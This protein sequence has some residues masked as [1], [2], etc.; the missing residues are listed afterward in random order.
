MSFTALPMG[1]SARVQRL[2]PSAL[3]SGFHS[4]CQRMTNRR[5]GSISRI[6]DGRLALEEFAKRA[7]WPSL[8]AAFAEHKV[9]L[10]SDT[11]KQAG[12]DP[13]F[14]VIR[15]PTRRGQIVDVP[16]A[17]RML[18]DDNTSLTKAFLW[19][20]DREKGPDV[21]FNHVW[22]QSDDVPYYTA[23][24]N[25]CCTPAFLAKACDTHPV[26]TEA[27]RYRAEHLYGHRPQGVAPARKPDAYEELNWAPSPPQLS[28]LQAAF[29]AR[30]NAAPMARPAIAAREI[31][32]RFSNGP[33]A[34][35][36]SAVAA[37]S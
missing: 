12:V 10:H 6:F 11:V 3:N 14:P 15:D 9:F 1:S 28:D 8:L 33:D 24:W 25:L 26:I 37:R 16:G 36:R 5:G 27:L 7:G 13:I 17:G 35:L 32:W 20:A 21:Q 30:L 31:G 34:T 2:G 23:L 18:L 29:R 22:R 4:A 19:A